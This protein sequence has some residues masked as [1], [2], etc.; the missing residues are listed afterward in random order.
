MITEIMITNI[1]TKNGEI[2]NP[3]LITNCDD[4]SIIRIEIGHEFAIV[5]IDELRLAIRQIALKG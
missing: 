5:P 4:K 2:N 3:L 1:Y